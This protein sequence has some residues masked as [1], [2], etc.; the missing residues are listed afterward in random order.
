MGIGNLIY[1]KIPKFISAVRQFSSITSVH[2]RGLAFKLVS[3]TW[4]TKYRARTFNEKEPEMLDW[5][6]EKLHDRDVF[7]DVGA[8]M[9][10]HSIYA[11]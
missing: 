1:I 4:I 5:L 11:G 6:D 7:I 2:S 9:G 8:N 3:D 10:I